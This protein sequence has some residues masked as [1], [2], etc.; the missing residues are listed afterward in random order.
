MS[1]R[2][3]ILIDPKVQ[4][5]IIRRLLM[6]WCLTVLTLV[7]IGVGAQ[8]VYAPG[9]QT[10]WQAVKTSFGA[11]LP[12]L[13]VMMMLVPV[14]L[15]DIVKLSNRFA[16]PMLRLRGILNELAEGRRAGDLKF[17]PGD[18]WQET[19][20]DFNRFYDEHLALLNRCEELENEVKSLSAKVEDSSA[21][22]MS[23]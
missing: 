10:F 1:Q 2:N 18:F 17:R 5:A 13:C 8:L 11:Q 15:R 22:E 9:G 16:G 3:R 20:T 12:L 4:W 6:H 23:P 14:Y 7:A 21:V 19:A